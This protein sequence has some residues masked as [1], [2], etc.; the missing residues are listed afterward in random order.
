MAESVQIAWLEGGELRLPE[1]VG[2]HREVVL[3]LPLSRL[4]ARVVRIPAANLDDPEG[5]LASAMKPLSPFP[6]EPLTV[7]SETLRETEDGRVVLAAALPEGSA[8]DIAGALDGAGVNVTR[9]DALA[10][11]RLHLALPKFAA[12]GDAKRR[13]FLSADADCLS[14]FVLD[15]DIPVAVRA[16][17]PGG[18]VARELTLCLL[19]AESFAGPSPLFEIAACGDIAAWSVGGFVDSFGVP[20]RDL[21]GAGDAVAG[22]AARA[23]TPGTLDALPESWRTV[24]EETR[25]KRRMTVA[26]SVAGFALL[27]AL[28]VLVG[29]PWVYGSRTERSRRSRADQTR[30]YEQVKKTMDQVD[31][32]KAISDLNRG[33][34]ETL[35]AVVTALAAADV[36]SAVSL[37]RWEFRRNEKLSFRGYSQGDDQT[38]IWRF[39]EALSAMTLDQISGR[40]EDAG[41]PFFTN[42]E[43]KK[44]VLRN[45][46]KAQDKRWEFEIE[47]SFETLAEEESF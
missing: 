6:D 11:G 46:S 28:A 39:K 30:R 5:Y 36:N 1:S 45:A 7:G 15:D 3:A 24:L 21:G 27:V 14:V 42:V 33:G 16:I 41:I 8:D 32:V 12:S 10:F 40:E 29:T 22:V 35:R 23:A 38:P 17:S 18:D 43:S 19:E 2:K 20:V 31:A 37:E 44:T 13:L 34:L 47:C 25:F 9:I 4:I 26:F